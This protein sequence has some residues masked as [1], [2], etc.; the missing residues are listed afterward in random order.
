[1][2]SG[3]MSRSKKGEDMD[4][5]R[6]IERIRKLLRLS[7]SANPHEAA[8]AAQRVQ[9]MLSEYNIT[10]DSI[11]CDA[12]TASARR[13]DRKTRKAL[14]NGRM[15]LPPERHGFLT[16]TI[17][18][19]NLPARPPLSALVPIRKCAAG[20]TAICIRRCY[21]WLPSTCAVPPVGSVPQNR[22]ARLGTLFFSAR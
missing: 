22:S 3:L 13:V 5:D 7:Q 14:E 11:G 12:E 8:L 1:M 21:V 15:S 10:M 6:I 4:Q 18:T 17:T 20:C 16:V 2:I 9:Q 19:T